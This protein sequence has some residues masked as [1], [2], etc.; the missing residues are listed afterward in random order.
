MTG[1]TQVLSP[2]F[3]GPGRSRYGELV[4]HWITEMTQQFT[5]EELLAE[6]QQSK[7]TVAPLNDLKDILENPQLKARNYLREEP[8]MPYGIG[9]PGPAYKTEPD[10]FGV[11]KGLKE[12]GGD[13][14]EV[15]TELA[16]LSESR[17]ID[18]SREG[19]L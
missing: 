11:R 13:N 5:T 6:A 12:P 3:E 16:G 1:E 9:F 8:W 7:I 10:H 14:I 2:Q 15:Y 4:D 17:I 19:V 18:L